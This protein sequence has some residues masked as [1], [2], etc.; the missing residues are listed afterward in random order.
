MIDDAK[1]LG[2]II[3]KAAEIWPDRVAIICEDQR[4]SYREVLDRVNWLAGALLKL[5]VKKGDKVAVLFTN[6]PQWAYA[7]YAI[8]KIGAIVVPINTRYSVKEMKYILGHSDTTTLIMME[9]FRKIDYMAMIKEICPEL[10][11]CV[12]GDLR[13][14]N[15]PVL[16]NI[17]VFGN[18]R[19]EGTFDFSALMEMGQGQDQTALVAAQSEVGPDDIAH[20]PYTSGTTG[21]PKGVLTT[22]QQYLSLDLA[23]IKEIGGFTKEDRLLIPAPFSHNFGNTQGIHMPALCGAAS[24]FIENFDDRK[25]LELIEKEQCTVFTGSPTMF[26][27][28]LRD[29]HFSSYDLSSLR[30]GLITAAPAPVSIIEEIQSKMGFEFLVS[31]YGM[32]ENSGATS[33][34]RPEDPPEVVSATVGRVLRPD[35]EIKVVDVKTGEDLPV[36]QPGELCTRGP[37]VMKGYYKMPEATASLI[38]KGGWFHTGD[39]AI[40]DESGY[41]RITG[42][43]KDVFMPGGLNV[44][45]EEVEDVLYTH[46]KVK[47][48]SV[49][50]VPDDVMGEEGAAFVELREGQVATA[51]E[52]IEFCKGRLANFKI[53][54]YVFFTKDFPTTTTGKIQRFVLRERAIKELGLEQ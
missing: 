43:S 50:G 45:P 21:D 19:H 33:I 42:R 22:H 11:T 5:G 28:M 54:K 7:E 37:L 18:R 12:P 29:E 35:Y 16:K 17:V 41:I 51:Q 15:L 2:E 47:Q 20:I 23:F 31:G 9:R 27:K 39:L 46:P 3:D 25:C 13:S 40:I 4:I 14:E 32:T 53:P 49:L 6:L 10:E 34:T 30:A 26:I 8:D 48:V 52:I 36:G 1:T 38:D 24:V 44:S